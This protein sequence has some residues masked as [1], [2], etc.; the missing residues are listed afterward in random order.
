MRAGRWWQFGRVVMRRGIDWF[1]S[2]FQGPLSALVTLLG[3][4]GISL[5]LVRLDPLWLVLLATVL[6]A[7]ALVRG[8]FSAWD[9]EERRASA[10]EAERREQA[11]D[12][13]RQQAVRDRQRAAKDLL[14]TLHEQ[15]LGWL[16]SHAD[17]E[18]VT[19][20]EDQ[21]LDFVCRAFGSAEYARLLSL[22]GLPARPYYSRVAGMNAQDATNIQTRCQQLA[23]LTPRVESILLEDFD[24]QRWR[25][26]RKTA[27]SCERAPPN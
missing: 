2:L 26:D 25:E 1:V 21:V 16:A 3:L 14:G 7:F 27:L 9:N 20:W 6:I 11:N 4:G 10:A 17:T 24:P 5:V 22:G 18:T 13:D 8:A 12:A 23:E 19:K 15:G